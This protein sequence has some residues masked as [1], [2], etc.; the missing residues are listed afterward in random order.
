M[1]VGSINSSSASGAID[2]RPAAQPPITKGGLEAMRDR[3][4]LDGGTVP[5]GL[6]LL[7]AKFGDAVGRS[8]KMTIAEFETFAAENGV[9]LP[10][11]GRGGGP[12]GTG[13]LGGGRPLS[14]SGGGGMTAAS[15]SKSSDAVSSATDEELRTL[16]AKGDAQA[17]RELEKRETAKTLAK[18]DEAVPAT[19]TD[20][21]V[22][23]SKIDTYA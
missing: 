20:Q 21:K 6:D 2:N 5:P 12:G 1:P 11:P 19:A 13:S 15:S 7:I 14:A 10:G 4:T 18:S 17:I 9:T 16:A 8:G 23:G 3:I 22:V